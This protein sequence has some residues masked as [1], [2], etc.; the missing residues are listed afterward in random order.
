MQLG[1]NGQRIKGGY[2]HIQVV[3]GARPALALI[4]IL[5]GL[6]IAFAV[7]PLGMLFAV[8]ASGLWIVTT[9]YSI[10]YMRAHHEEH[11]TRYYACF[12]IAIFGAVGAALAGNMLTL[13]VF[14]EV[15]TISTYPLVAHHG[16]EKA[17]AGARTYL[18]ILL[19]TSIAMLLLAVADD[20]IGLVIIAVFYGD[21][22]LPAAPQWLGLVLVGMAWCLALRRFGVKPVEGSD[23]F[24]LVMAVF[25]AV[26]LISN[27]AS[28]AKFVDW[29]VSLFGVRLAFDA[30]TILFPISYIFG[31]ILTEVYGFRRSRRIIWIGFACNALMAATLALV[32]ALPGEQGWSS[33]L[34]VVNQ[35][36]GENGGA[37]L[38]YRYLLGATPRIVVGSLIAYFAGEFSNSYVLAKMKIWTRGRW[39]WTR[40]IGSTLVG[41]GVDTV[42]FVLIA[43]A[44]LWHNGHCVIVT[45]AADE[46]MQGIHHRMPVI[47]T[48]S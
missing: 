15:L 25:V 39:L 13:F 41:E 16:T 29:G 28:A 22:E 21:P 30:G 40:T 14:Y 12:A 4:H 11:Q 6:S 19:T 17:M 5:P 47:L 34:R 9:C 31:D 24:D 43:F 27:V 3:A 38:A 44:G 32:G 1:R 37:E 2:S 26:L 10:G 42:L 48:V 23:K 8:V 18:S 33:G 35:M 7:E 36:T 45:C 20:A 46:N